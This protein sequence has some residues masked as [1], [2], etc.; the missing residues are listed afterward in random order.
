M[1]R[2]ESNRLIVTG[3]VT[4]ATHVAL[5]DA[6]RTAGA[7]PA[8]ID[9]SEVTEVDSSALSLLFAWQREA[10]ANERRITSINVPENL[11]SLAQLYGVTELIERN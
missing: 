1:I 5:R 2:I 4:I 11:H 3:P 9:W 6:A 8:T 10:L 7:L